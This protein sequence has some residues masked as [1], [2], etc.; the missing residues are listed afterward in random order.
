MWRALLMLATIFRGPLPSAFFDQ[1][2][3][4]AISRTYGRK[5]DVTG[6]RGQL[7][8]PTK[9]M[10]RPGCRGMSLRS[11]ARD[12]VRLV[13]LVQ[14]VLQEQGP[15]MIRPLIAITTPMVASQHRLNRNGSWVY[16]RVAPTIRMMPISVRRV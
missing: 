9:N 8:T 10:I 14:N 12:R 3:S 2:P 15:A 6:D 4:P 5:R 13:E 16:Q 11:R 1:P 7:A